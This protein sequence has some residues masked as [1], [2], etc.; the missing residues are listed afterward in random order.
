MNTALDIDYNI[1]N[2]FYEYMVGIYFI[3]KQ[4]EYF[5]CFI[6]T[7]NLYGTVINFEDIE[8]LHNEGKKTDNF[9]TILSKFSPININSDNKKDII[10]NT[11][12]N[13]DNLHLLIETVPEPISLVTLLQNCSDD[14]KKS[15]IDNL[16]YF[17][18]MFNIYYQIVCVLYNLKG[19]FNHCDLHYAKILLIKIP[20]N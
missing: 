19:K 16:S 11:C 17:I 10:I 3:N 7:Y 1:D 12:K 5:P 4:S 13:Y 14:I 6:K 20:N 8:V 15:V 18:E 2:I 9:R